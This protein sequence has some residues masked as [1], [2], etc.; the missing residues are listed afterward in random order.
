[1]TVPKSSF[2]VIITFDLIKGE[3][4]VLVQILT[5]ITE[6]IPQ[7]LITDLMNCICDPDLKFIQTTWFRGVNNSFKMTPIKSSQVRSDKA[8]NMAT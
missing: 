1:M 4:K 3:N 6:N 7:L 5:L 2:T 8:N